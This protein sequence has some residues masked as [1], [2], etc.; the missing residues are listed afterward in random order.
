MADITFLTYWKVA[1]ERKR[2]I[3]TLITLSALIMTFVVMTAPRE[4]TAS[5]S[6]F[7]PAGPANLFSGFSSMGLTMGGGGPTSVESLTFLVKSRRMAEGIVDHFALA[8]KFQMTRE[9]ATRRARRMVNGYDL[10]KGTLFVIE[11]TSDDPKFSAD[12]ANFCAEN[13]NAINEQL[14]LTSDK[15]FVKVID[16][17]QPPTSANPRYLPKKVLGAILFSGIGSYFFFFLA[18]YFKMLCEEEKR[19]A[20]SEDAEKILKEF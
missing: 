9:R 20:I 2:A 16:S 5:V 13:L 3:L 10:V 12:L 7:P 18:E 17:A 19:K 11:A 1:K 8:E 6:V 4:Y 14:I 15:P